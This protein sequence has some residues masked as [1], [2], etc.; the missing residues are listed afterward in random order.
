MAAGICIGAIVYIFP[1]V[2][3]EGYRLVEQVIRGEFAFGLW[4]IAALILFKVVATSLTLGGGGAGG[5]FA[6]S[7]VI[8][9]LAGI[10]FYKILMLVFPSS[11]FSGGLVFALC[12]MAGMLSGTLQ[13]PLTGIF[14][15]VEITGGYDVILPL[16]LVSFLTSNLVKLVEK[17][18]I[19]FYELV[20]KGFLRRPRTDARILTDIR[21]KELL[22]KD[23][24]PIHPEMRLGD[25]IPIVIR[26]SRNFFPVLDRSSQGYLGMVDLHSLK[27]YLFDPHLK[28]SILV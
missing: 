17:N 14:L 26:S 19:Y 9:S 10:L 13:A 24:I 18:S 2:R 8:G 6:P 28:E 5:V 7:L 16:L 1:S 3:G 20:E 27:P 23:V 12:G 22:E 25:V 15:I 4:M 21:V 11:S